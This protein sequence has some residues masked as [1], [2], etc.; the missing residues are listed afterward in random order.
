MNL[1]QLDEDFIPKR[2]K[3]NKYAEVIMKLC[4]VGYL[5][6]AVMFYQTITFDSDLLDPLI[7]INT[8]YNPLYAYLLF[9]VIIAGLISFLL[10]LID[11]Y[12]GFKIRNKL[13]MA[14]PFLQIII[15][16]ALDIA[17]INIVN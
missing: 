12:N 4:L 1:E 15:F 6:E 10:V 3:K 16:I 5:L 7:S 14:T 17:F 2:K 13:L 11:R 9:W 8:L